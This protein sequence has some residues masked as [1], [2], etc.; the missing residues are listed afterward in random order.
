M[1]LGITTC[2]TLISIIFVSYL[3]FF[4]HT[5]PT[6][7][8]L[9]WNWITGEQTW[10]KKA[11]WNIS[12]PTMLVTKIDSRPTRVCITSSGRGFHCKLVQFEPSFYKEFLAVEGFRYYWWANRISFNM[13]YDEEYRGL[14]DI[15]R[16]HAFAAKK[17]N[18]LKILED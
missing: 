14:R 11:G 4:H 7:T 8:A 12:S 2:V 5:E 6:E 10:I 9:G 13:G 3:L 15:L 17:Y 16:G 1:R 18:F